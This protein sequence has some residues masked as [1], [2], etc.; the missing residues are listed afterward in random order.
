MEG[1][2]QDAVALQAGLL[3]MLKSKIGGLEE[4]DASPIP[5][6]PVCS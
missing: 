1:S 5:K 2:I 3:I 6:Q 4:P